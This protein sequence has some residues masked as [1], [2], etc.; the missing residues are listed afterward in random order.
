MSAYGFGG[1]IIYGIFHKQIKKPF[2]IGKLNVRFLL[3]FVY[4]CLI[5]TMVELLATYI[6]ELTGT[7]VY[8][9]LGLQRSLYEFPG[10]GLSGCKRPFWRTRLGDYL[11]CPA[12]LQ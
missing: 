7:P 10:A 8:R 1:M 3:L 4:I 9:S 2:Y 6:I 11:W 5:T 12:V